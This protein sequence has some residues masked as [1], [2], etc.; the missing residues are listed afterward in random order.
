MKDILSALLHSFR[1]P[2]ISKDG[3]DECNAYAI[4]EILSIYWVL[5]KAELHPHLYCR[6]CNGAELPL[7]GVKIDG[8]FVYTDSRSVYTSLPTGYKPVSTLTP[9]LAKYGDDFN[10]EMIECS[11]ILSNYLML[12]SDLIMSQS[13]SMSDYQSSILSKAQIAVEMLE[14]RD[15]KEYRPL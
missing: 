15:I 6:T 2:G 7:V 5:K 13:E 3:K 10:N 11:T 8:K 4:E 1:C 12:F 9:Y 14:N